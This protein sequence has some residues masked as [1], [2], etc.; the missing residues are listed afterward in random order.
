MQPELRNVFATAF[1]NY[2]N[3]VPAGAHATVFAKRLTVIL[4]SHRYVIINDTIQDIHVLRIL[5]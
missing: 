3:N 2:L 5:F 4:S 1:H